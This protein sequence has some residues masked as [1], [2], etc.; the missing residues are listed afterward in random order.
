MDTQLKYRNI[1]RSVLQNYADYRSTLS[2]GYGAQVLFDDEHGQYL[3]LDIGWSGDQY[4]HATP[5]HLSL[6][7]SKIWIQ[8]DDTEEGVVN[9]LIAAGVPKDDLVLGFRHPRVRQHTGFAVA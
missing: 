2:D 7:D 4:L 3:V 6:I 5:I 9:D 8:Y 1:I